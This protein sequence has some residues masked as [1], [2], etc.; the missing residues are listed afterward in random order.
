MTDTPPVDLLPG[1]SMA[2]FL[3]SSVHDMKNSLAVMAGFLETALA[4]AP[5]HTSTLYRQTSQAFYETQRIN[6][7][8]I[9]LLAL[10]KIDQ[11]Y[12]PFDPQE[13]NLADLATDA[14][15][16]V[17]SLARLNGITLEYE[18]P[19]DLYGWVDYEL[20]LGVL[21]QALHNALRYTRDSV[22]CLIAADPRGGITIRVEDNGPGFPD[23]LLQQGNARDRGVSF[24]TGGTGLGLHF[25]AVVAGLHRSGERRGSTRLENGGRLGGGCLCLELP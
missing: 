7:H 25:A 10:Y 6:D 12:Y 20:I 4:E 16:R 11:D 18:C 2:N 3:V 8:L 21:M 5:D 9:Q 15:S 19:D 22:I 24:A 1:M 23:F 14:L 13:Q 17:A